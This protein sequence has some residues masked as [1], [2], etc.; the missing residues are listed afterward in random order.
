MSGG[1]CIWTGDE[2]LT[3]RMHVK[4]ANLLKWHTVEVER[5]ERISSKALMN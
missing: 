1:V 2:T 5:W 4:N 3:L